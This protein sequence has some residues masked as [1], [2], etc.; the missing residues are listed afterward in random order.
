MKIIIL[1]GGFAT[2]LWPLTE[3]K[4]KPLLLLNGETILSQLLKKIDQ[5]LEIIISTNKKFKQEFEAEIKNFPKK[6]IKIF[7]EDSF[8]DGEKLGALGAIST[9][10]KNYKIDENI[11]IFAGDNLL[12]K[13]KLEKIFCKNDNAKIIVRDIKNLLEAQ[14]FGVVEIDKYLKNKNS[15]TVKNFEEKPKKPKSTLV[16]TGFCTI[17]KNLF[18]ILHEFAK[19]FPDNLGGIFA[20]FLKQKKE[21]LAEKVE[22]DWFDIG[23]FDT[24]LQAHKKLQKENIFH[25]K[26]YLHSTF[27]GK[28]FVGKNCK[29][30]NCKIFNSII[31]PGTIL[32]NCYISE[33]VI[34][35]K[36]LLQDLDLNRKLIRKGTKIIGGQGG[37]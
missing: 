21:V 19:K 32:S 35:E 16:S 15:Y 37:N 13:L 24:Y 2:R 29:I 18:P 4:A 9:V 20:E 17:G 26:K 1:A 14:K 31:Y 36:C 27:S 23:S 6:N 11:I 8:S 3:Q 28:N 12:P 25:S 7:C 22:G 34:D 30:N 33:S 10:I 5:D